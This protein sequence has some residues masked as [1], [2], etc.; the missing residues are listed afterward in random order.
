MPH[1]TNHTQPRICIHIHLL[2]LEPEYKPHLAMSSRYKPYS[3]TT[4]WCPVNKLGRPNFMASHTRHPL[5]TAVLGEQTACLRLK[6]QEKAI[7]QKL[8]T[9][10]EALFIAYSDRAAI[11]GTHFSEQFLYAKKLLS[12]RINQLTREHLLYTAQYYELHCFLL[13]AELNTLRTRNQITRDA[14]ASY[15]SGERSCPT[16]SR[17]PKTKQK[18]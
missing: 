16:C 3:G 6:A 10:S 5:E 7:L 14:V 4:F 8:N 1:C 18:N 2:T 17:A 13:T 15:N 11:S 9:L 12:I